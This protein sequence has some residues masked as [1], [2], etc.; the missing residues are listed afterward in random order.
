MLRKPLTWKTMYT[1]A[2]FEYKTFKKFTHK[3][4]FAVTYLFII[5]TDLRDKFHVSFFL[6]R[7]MHSTLHSQNS[8]KLMLVFSRISDFYE[9]YFLHFGS[10]AMSNPT[11]MWIFIIKRQ[12]IYALY[13]AILG[14]GRE[15]KPLKFEL[16]IYWFTSTRSM[17]NSETQMRIIIFSISI[18]GMIIT[19]NNKDEESEEEKNLLTENDHESSKSGNS[20]LLNQVLSF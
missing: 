13:Q 20:K 1:E 9:I 6:W 11:K 14:S 5:N 19:Q 18:K 3:I 12:A 16:W 7:Q 10:V 15:W 4:G 17:Q 2:S 8:I